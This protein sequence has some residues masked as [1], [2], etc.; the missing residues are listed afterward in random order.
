MIA[1]NYDEL[2][3]VYYP[4]P[5]LSAAAKRLRRGEYELD[6]LLKRMGEVMVEEHGVGLAAPQ[7]G[8]SRK[9]FV[10]YLDDL[11]EFI[12]PVVVRGMGEVVGEEGCLSFPEIYGMVPRFEKIVVKYL[13]RG[14]KEHREEFADFNARVLQHEI[15]HLNGVLLIDRAI[16]GTIHRK[17]REEIEESSLA[18]EAV[19]L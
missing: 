18:R 2:A 12:N 4:N 13:D 16:E 9:L 6:R 5:I 19:P 8:V 15:D 14:F 7:I 11:R 10:A 1:V 17:E 3:I